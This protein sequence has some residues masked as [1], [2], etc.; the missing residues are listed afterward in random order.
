MPAKKAKVVSR[1]FDNSRTYK[2]IGLV[3]V[4]AVFAVLGVKLL[5]NSSA[6]TPT[7]APAVGVY[8]Y[9]DA[10]G[11]DGINIAII[12]DGVAG[13]G[14]QS[15]TQIQPGKQLTYV[16]GGKLASTSSC[17]YLRAYFN[18]KAAPVSPTA[19][20]TLVGDGNVRTVSL[21]VEY[22]GNYHEVC[23]P[24]GKQAQ[25]PYNVANNSTEAS[26]LVYQLIK[27]Y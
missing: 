20:V 15:V 27:H 24:S 4:V 10:A 8:N 13:I 2:L 1:N 17:Y 16:L 9:T 19:S 3:V 12:Q 22:S 21:P 11:V 5:N 14:V 7:P 18:G 23:V 26:I 25:P 6:A